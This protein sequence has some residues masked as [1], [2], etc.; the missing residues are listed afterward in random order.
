M[1]LHAF[2]FA[3][4]TSCLYACTAAATPYRLELPYPRPPA[5]TEHRDAAPFSCPA[6]PSA[7]P[8]DLLMTGVYD[9]DDPERDNTNPDKQA[10][11]REQTADMGRFENRLQRMTNAYYTGQTGIEQARCALSWLNSWAEREAL[12]GRVNSAG[13]SIRH[14]TL[15]SLASAFGQIRD[16][17]NLDRKQYHKVRLWLR[18]LAKRVAAGY[19][20][21]K[22][23]R[24]NNLAYWAAWS[25]AM[26]GIATNDFE[27]Y[28]WGIKRGMYGV[29]DIAN[30]GT[31][32]L[33]LK[34]GTKAMLYHQFA[35]MPLMMLAEA[36]RANGF[37][38]YNINNGQL[39]RLADRV[40]SGIEDPSL[41]EKLTGFPQQGVEDLSSGNL[42][43]LEV[44]AARF[45]DQRANRLLDRYRPFVSRRLGG[46]MTLL[47]GSS[48]RSR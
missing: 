30:D 7:G 23:R 19:D 8:V 34:R 31:L 38:L 9:K 2:A 4:L 48:D 32:P 44:Y 22:N 29:E 40:L 11:Y 1:R 39:R 36:G 45:P 5:S 37:D 15:A 12:L 17:P 46:D 47:F 3:L 24:E 35:L 41:F 42:A 18:R 21:E 26:T 14:W 43:W 13:I 20:S 33:E 10:E 16:A 25:V 6:P 28:A 27:L